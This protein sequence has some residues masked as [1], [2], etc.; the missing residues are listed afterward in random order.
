MATPEIAPGVL[1]AAAESVPVA[2]DRILARALSRLAGWLDTYSAA[3][4]RIATV[5][6]VA[7][8]VVAAGASSYNVFGRYVLH[9]ELFGAGDVVGFAFLWTIWM[10][11]SLAVRRGEATAITL[12]AA[13]GPRL[14]RRSLRAFSAAGLAVLLAYCCVLSVRY[15]GSQ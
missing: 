14:W 10:G 11:V 1:R 9:E 8:V 4:V 12:L 13:H 15:A 7:G 5:L 6:T 3:A 2:G